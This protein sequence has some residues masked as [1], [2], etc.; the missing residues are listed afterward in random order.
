MVVDV[1]ASC[2]EEDHVVSSS[3]PYFSYGNFRLPLLVLCSTAC[4]GEEKESL[5][6]H[7]LFVSVLWRTL[8]F[9]KDEEDKEDDAHDDDTER[10]C[11]QFCNCR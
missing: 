9:K 5:E 11:I 7:G 4:G 2:E 10:H 3:D 1:V 8:V 6:N